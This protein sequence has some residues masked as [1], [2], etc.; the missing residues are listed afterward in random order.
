MTLL[1]LSPTLDGLQQM[2]ESCST[3]TKR[4]NLSFSTNENP[5]KSKTKC[6]AFLKKKR[7]LRC[8]KVNDKPLPW[9]DTVTHLGTTV[10]ENLEKMSQDLVEKRAQYI[11]VNNELTQEFYYAHHS[12]KTKVNQ[13]FNTHFYGTIMGLVLFKFPKAGKNLE[14][15][16]QADAFIATP[17]PQ[18]P[19]RTSYWITP[20]YAF[21]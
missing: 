10:T 15:I 16:A 11:A 20:Y 14:C 6:M 18:V 1:L 5:Q 9:V 2:I 19:N 21:T 8:L 3:Y 4:H 13:N 17:N 7:N 12:T